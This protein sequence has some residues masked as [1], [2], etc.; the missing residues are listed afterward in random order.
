M[1]R[2]WKGGVTAALL[3]VVMITPVG[4]AMPFSKPTPL[5][6]HPT[7]SPL[8]SVFPPLFLNTPAQCTTPT[9]GISFTDGDIGTCPGTSGTDCCACCT[10]TADC[11]GYTLYSGICYLKDLTAAPPT[12]CPS[13]IS[14]E[15]APPMPPTPH[16]NHPTCNVSTHHDF[17]PDAGLVSSFPSN[18]AEQCCVLCGEEPGCVAWTLYAQVCYLKNQYTG[19]VPCSDCISGFAPGNRSSS[20][21]PPTPPS[22]QPLPPQWEMKGMTFT[23]GRYCPEVAFGTPAAEEALRWLKTTGT[24][25]VSIVT[26]WC[27]VC[28]PLIHLLLNRYHLVRC[29]PLPQPHPPPHSVS[30][31]TLP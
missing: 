4:S 1:M 10:T 20:N 5:P 24:N 3:S 19:S 30:P 13:C 7:P 12:Q 27:V 31:S 28:P 26:T 17:K 16:S 22:P 15:I 14:G 29:L 9:S 8:L 23:G 25:W 2:P 6:F 18:T 11:V 21:T